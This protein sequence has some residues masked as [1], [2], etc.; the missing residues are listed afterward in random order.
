MAS[1]LPGLDAGLPPP[2]DDCGLLVLLAVA[3]AVVVV[4]AVH[5]CADAV[6]VG[7][8]GAQRKRGSHGP[9]IATET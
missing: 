7:E 5:Q 2:D 1:D 4:V 6:A 8:V 3:A 9:D